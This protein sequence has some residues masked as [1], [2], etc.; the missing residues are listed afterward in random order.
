MTTLYR[1]K[2]R[3][4]VP[5]AEEDTWADNRWP[6]GFSLVYC[7]PGSRSARFSINPDTAGMQAAIMEREDKLQDILLDAMAVRPRIRP[8]TPRQR[9]AWEA[10]IA[11]FGDDRFLL[12]YASAQEV[13]WRVV[14]VLKS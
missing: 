6:E 9:A 14:D 11:A 2:G 1:K 12:E 13:I 5:V 3:R 7:R 8:I 10:L 4:Y